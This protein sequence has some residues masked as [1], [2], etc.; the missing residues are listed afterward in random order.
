MMAATGDIIAHVVSNNPMNPSVTDASTH[1]RRISIV[2]EFA[3]NTT[4]HG[5][6]GIARGRSIPNRIFWAISFMAFTSAMVYFITKA[7][8]A[9]FEYPSQ[10]KVSITSQ[11]IQHFP[12]FTICNAGGIRAD[13][14]LKTYTEYIAHSNL[15]AT[16]N[17]SVIPKLADFM[18]LYFSSLVNE[19]GSLG[20]YVFPLESMLMSC[21]Y[22]GIRCS[23]NDF[24]GFDSAEFGRCYTFNAKRRNGSLL[25]NHETD[26]NGKLLL[27][28]YV[29]AHQ[30]VPTISEGVAMLA[31]VHDNTQLP[32]I[33]KSGM[34]LAPGF[35]HRL[36]YVKRDIQFLS[37]PYSSCTNEIPRA[38]QIMFEKYD[39]AEYVYSEELCHMLCSQAYIYDQCGC[40]SPLQWNARTIVLPGTDKT[41]VARLCNVTNPCFNKAMNDFDLTQSIQDLYCSHCLHQCSI[42]QF[43]V[44]SSLSGTPPQWLIPFI[45]EFV[46]NTSIPLPDDWSTRWR[47]HI[48]SSYLS[49]ELFSESSF[50]ETY[51]QT[52]TFRPFDIFSNV[53]GLSSLWIGV[54]FLT[55]MEFIEMLFLLIQHQIRLSRSV[56]PEN[57]KSVNTEQ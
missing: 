25:Y 47:E 26:S 55:I 4:T 12:A 32:M 15:T 41:I 40:V 18:R 23:V 49:L 36:S 1:R 13:A 22:V 39:G 11:R 46:Q 37:E 27:R 50:I 3:L 21:Y 54:S 31:M 14:L 42:T 19:D 7:L 44:Q 51:T 16:S 20:Q 56:N 24:I 30:Y 43:V 57:K 2:R 6:P 45:R 5:I 17:N 10:T 38:M 34:T 9:Y 29:H 28:L 35:Q 33:E 53:G 52:P 48:L 8:C